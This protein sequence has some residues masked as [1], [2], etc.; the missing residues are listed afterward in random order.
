MAVIGEYG[1]RSRAEKQRSEQVR[2]SS[3]IL[4]IFASVWPILSECER[5]VLIRG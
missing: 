3:P 2:A 1:Q 5:S 4:Y